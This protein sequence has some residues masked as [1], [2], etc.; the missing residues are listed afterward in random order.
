MSAFFV[1]AAF[2]AAVW[3]LHAALVHQEEEPTP[4]QYDPQVERFLDMLARIRAYLRVW[5]VRP[6][7]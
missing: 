3:T 5:H 7:V 1:V 6:P 4:E 2:C